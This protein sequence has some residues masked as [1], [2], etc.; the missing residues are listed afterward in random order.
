MSKND[1]RFKTAAKKVKKHLKEADLLAKKSTG[2]YWEAGKEISNVKDDLKKLRIFTKWQT[3]NDLKPERVWEALKIYEHFST[4]EEAK[5]YNIVDALVAS[6]S[7]KGKQSNK[8]GSNFELRWKPAR[9]MWDDG[10]PRKKIAEYYEITDSALATRIKKWRKE[11]GWFPPR[12]KPAPTPVLDKEMKRLIY[13]QAVKDIEKSR[14][15]KLLS[16]DDKDDDFWFELGMKNQE[17]VE[18]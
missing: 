5:K 8:S 12:D 1:V 4:I 14:I 3:E 18:A 15:E 6:G 17:K 7:R 11:Y 10:V 2:C 9:N 13:E 16:L